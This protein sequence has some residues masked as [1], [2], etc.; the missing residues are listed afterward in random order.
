[1]TDTATV[2]ARD[3]AARW[4]I[5]PVRARTVLAPLAPV[6]R[7]MRTGAMLYDETAAE[8]LRTGMPGQGTRTDL[9][10]TET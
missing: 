9:I 4:G 10:P 7:D 8:A 3:C 6:G 1:M 5:S 2:T